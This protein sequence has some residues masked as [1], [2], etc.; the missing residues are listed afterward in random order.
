M[1]SFLDRLRPLRGRQRDFDDFDDFDAMAI[2]PVHRVRA[3][4]SHR[5]DEPRH[6]PGAQAA[7]SR[8]VAVY[9]D[10]SHILRRHAPFWAAVG[11]R[12]GVSCDSVGRALVALSLG[13]RVPT[14]PRVQRRARCAVKIRVAAASGGAYSLPR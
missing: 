2:E 14:A 3:R 5:S 12:C 10:P 7:A 13:S 1:G 8:V 6:A 9:P 11:Q 4:N